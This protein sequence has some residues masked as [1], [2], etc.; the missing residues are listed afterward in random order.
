VVGRR[1]ETLTDDAPVLAGDIAFRLND[2]YGFPVDLTVELA[3][4][5]GVRVDR[6]G[7]ETA[8][9]EQRQRSRSGRKADLARQAELTQL[10]DDIAR[11]TGETTF[12]GYEAT[13]ADGRVAAIVRDGTSYQ[14]LEAR[15]EAELR[16]EA[17]AAA[18]V[19]LDRTPF[20]AERGGQVGDQG[21]IRDATTDELLFTVEDTQRPV[22]GLIVHRGTLHGRIA[23][24]QQVRAVVEPIRR[25]RTMRNHTG[26]HLLHRAIRN[27]IGPGAKQAGS[28]V[29]PGYLRFDYPF[30]RALTDDER[31]AI[32]AEVRATV[33]EDLP[34]TVAYMPYQEAIEGGADAFF[35]EKYTETVRTVRVEGYPSFELCG[36]THCRA[37]G[38]VGG[39]VITSDRSIGSGMRRIE[40]LTGDAAD[41]WSEAHRATVEDAAARA[42]A[43]TPNSL[44]G[45]IDEL[46]ARIKELEKR[47]RAGAAGGV[48]RAADAAR[49]ATHIGDVPV[50]AMAAPFTSMEELKAY[51]KDVRG[52]L[53]SGIIALVLDDDPPQVWVTVSD[54]LVARGVSAADLVGAAMGPLDGRGG[55]RPNMA[56]GKGEHRHEIQAAL[57]AIRARVAG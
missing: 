24:G 55:G 2:T 42:G 23:V 8:L 33:R 37:S 32:E 45:R 29:A 48:P 52:V 21:E 53:G 16:V 25:A 18:E 1:A 34:V 38:Q 54:D 40:A 36:G 46:Q 56:Q 10:Y 22:G 35:D 41:A 27:V 20:Y 13:T 11:A 12:L 4:E 28:L 6:A 7:F 17:G 9:E 3:A 47:L 49:G 30:D 50:V 51:A 57:D 44:P 15:P 43:Q 26:T 39:F 5:Y 19:V 14:E 31:R